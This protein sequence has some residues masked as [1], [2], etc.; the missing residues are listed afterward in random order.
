[1]CVVLDVGVV[2]PFLPDEVLEDDEDNV[3]TVLIDVYLRQID[4]V[5]LLVVEDAHHDELE[6]HV[7]NHELE[8]DF[9]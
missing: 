4:A 8:G 1:M 9:A 5:K 3:D 2:V 6:V 7:V